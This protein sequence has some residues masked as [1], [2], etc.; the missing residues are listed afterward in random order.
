MRVLFLCNQWHIKKELVSWLSCPE[1][2]AAG[3]EFIRCVG[4]SSVSGPD[5]VTFDLAADDIHDIIARVPGEPPELIL[6]WEPGWLALPQRI[7]EAPVPVVALL[8]DWNLVLRP[9]VGMLGAFDYIFTDR[10][11]VQVIKNLG[12]S[13]V[14]YWPMWGH[15][16][17]RFQVIP[18]SERVWDITM[19]GNLSSDI[20]R[21]RAC[22]LY[23]L[24]KLSDRWRIR[25]AGGLYGED[26]LRMLNQSKITFN[27]SIRRE[28][29]MR[30]YEAAACGSLLFY[31]EENEEARDYFEDRVHC[32]LYNEGNF[33]ALIEYYLTHDEERERIVAAAHQRVKE[34]SQPKALLRLLA[35]IE[36]LGLLN[37]NRP[38]RAYA[39]QPLYERNKHYARQIFHT[40]TAGNLPLATNLIGEALREKPGEGA[41]LNDY[42]V[43]AAYLAEAQEDD[44]VQSNKA[45]QTAFAILERAV[46]ASPNAALP[47]INLG[48]FHKRQRQFEQ[49]TK[50]F[51]QAL[52]ILQ[53]GEDDATDLLELHFPFEHDQFRTQ[54]ET[55]Y[56]YFSG[57]EQTLRLARRC[58][59]IHKVGLALG[60]LAE[61]QGSMKQAAQAYHT[62][63]VARPD[64]GRARSALARCLAE[65]GQVEDALEQYEFAFVTDP[66]LSKDWF[67]YCELLVSLGRYQQA[68]QFVEERLRV[69]SC[70]PSLAHL[71]QPLRKQL[72]RLSGA[73]MEQAKVLVKA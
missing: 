65:L 53:R 54:Y 26:Y 55:L 36:E 29:N 67:G 45:I 51:V 15:D 50:Y 24:A 61:V 49:A 47:R 39:S 48:E 66:F 37:G 64:L 33:E 25:I 31:D 34:I 42:G 58:L 52:D 6:V 43:V 23:R 12:H 60:E 18:G 3:H 16:P 59:L 14:E 27:R 5:I 73:K 19:I 1:L 68:K 21:E 71:E 17:R 2:A 41:L 57:D 32:V 44:F 7:E 11:G 35:R 13:H 63:A 28:F 62:A 46:K 38:A 56:A 22:W 10:P 40:M 69:I 9:Q 30:C 4:D 8:S 70:I 20:Q 72:I